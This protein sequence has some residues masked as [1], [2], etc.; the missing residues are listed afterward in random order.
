M[1]LIDFNDLLAILVYELGLILD[2]V[3]QSRPYTFKVISKKQIEPLTIDYSLIGLCEGSNID[4]LDLQ[5][6][7]DE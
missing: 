7:N 4:D 2:A 1:T 3:Q 5:Y 6:G